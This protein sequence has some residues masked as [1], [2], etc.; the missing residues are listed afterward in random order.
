MLQARLP[1][2]RIKEILK[3]GDLVALPT[4]TVYGLAGDAF[5]SAALKKIF[6][7]KSRPLIDPL[8]IHI[9][10]TSQLYDLARTSL[11]ALNLVNHFWPGAL[12]IVLEKKTIVPDLATAGLPTVAI[13]MPSDLL[14]RQVLQYCN[15]PLAAPSANPFG[16]ISPTEASHV[17]KTLGD[18]IPMIIDGGPCS[19]G[20]ESTI[21][22]ITNSKEPTILRL[23]PIN[24]E[25]IEE[26]L[27]IPVN[28]VESSSN[29][30]MAQSS[31]GLLKHHYS[32]KTPLFFLKGE[33]SN[34]ELAVI[35]MKR[36]KKV[37]LS[38][39]WLSEDG[40]LKEVAK[41]LFSL[42]QKIDQKV[43]KAI[44]IE[45]PASEGIGIAILDRLRRAVHKS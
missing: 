14:M 1:L 36:P 22:D 45:K 25:A 16:Y 32:P 26:V 29:L 6:N 30:D 40:D 33:E 5:N 13:R 19:I 41:N 42:M 27:G 9:H 31:P 18:K 2:E 17:K 12:T 37:G 23:G 24:K 35:Y 38:D 20:I 10:K 15:F 21:L 7:V 28:F 34:K 43:F 8:I 11:E 3:R 39:F 44:Y 4:E